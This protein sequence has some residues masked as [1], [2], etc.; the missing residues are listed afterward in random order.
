MAVPRLAVVTPTFTPLGGGLLSV[1]NIVPDEARI[2]MGVAY[3]A[4]GICGMPSPTPDNCFIDGPDIG[5][6]MTAGGFGD[7]TA[8]SFGLY[9][10]VECW[11]DQDEDFSTIAKE[12]LLAGE[13]FGVEVQVRA[14]IL[15]VSPVSLGVTLDPVLA[16]AKAERYAR[17]N[18]SG[19]PVIHVSPYG[20]VVLDSLH[21]VK[22]DLDGTLRTTL[23][24]KI[25]VGGGYDATLAEA[26]TFNLWV[27]GQVNVWRGPVISTPD[28]RNYTLNKQR[29]IAQRLYAVT[30]DCIKAKATV[31]ATTPTNA[32]V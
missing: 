30:V 22:Q 18:Y 24:S 26:A 2:S 17:A 23:G 10:G 12:S 9:Q 6:G 27:T 28:V 25:A 16:L 11:I 32:G 31:N 7:V 19:I 14:E 20:L 15:D 29:G 3:P 4:S 8:D 5:S 1:A 21:L 13:T